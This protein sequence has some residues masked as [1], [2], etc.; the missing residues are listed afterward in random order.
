MKKGFKVLCIMLIV[1]LMSGCMKMN[2]DMSIHKDKSMDFAFTVALADSLMQNTGSQEIMSDEDLQE[3]KDEGFEVKEYSDGSMTGYTLT[4]RFKNIDDVSSENNII[5]DLDKAT[6]EENDIFTV[7]KGFFKNIYTVKI[8]NKTSSE[9]QNSMG[10]TNDNTYDN[11]TD[12][13]SDMDLSM[14]SASIDLKFNVNLPYKALNSNA[15]TTENDGKKLIWNLMDSNLKDIEFSFK[16]YNM[17]NIYLT[18]GFGI[19]ALVI[20][21]VIVNRKPKTKLTTPLP[22]NDDQVTMETDETTVHTNIQNPVENNS[23]TQNNELNENIQT[24]T[25]VSNEVNVSSPIKPDVEINSSNETVETLDIF[26]T[27]P[28]NEKKKL[29]EV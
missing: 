8:K 7:K 25:P 24:S 10:S 9:L 19:L 3:A 27:N 29:K 15:T 18:I 12:Y 22:V 4:K 17:K 2:V 26:N 1:F 16:L 13:T 6:K 5:F 14:L 21:I 11:S 23:F 28:D 20:I